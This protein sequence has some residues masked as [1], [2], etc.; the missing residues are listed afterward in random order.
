LNMSIQ[1]LFTKTI[2][3][4]EEHI[5]KFT[6]T[7]L[8]LKKIPD[9]KAEKVKSDENV[10]AIRRFLD[11]GG[12]C[13]YLFALNV[14]GVPKYLTDPPDPTQIKSKVVL[15]I[16]A[17]PAKANNKDEPIV[18]DIKNIDQEIIFMEINKEILQNLFS[19][20]SE[21]YS[22]V[23]ANPLNMHGWSDLVSKDLMDKFNVFL[24][25]TYVTI[26]QIKGRTLLPLPPTDATSSEK[27]SSKDKAQSLEAHLLHWTKQIKNVL[28]QDPESALKNG[29]HPDPLVEIQFW[30]DKSENLNSICD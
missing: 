18:I 24:A 3:D 4:P 12:N 21:V 6:L 10:D 5:L 1:Q 26:G 27:S 25:H 17:R 11:A 23:M 2:T 28:K 13:M 14:N 30:R 16:R 19:I 9:D 15:V 8:N 29:Q 20:C 7:Y 22:P